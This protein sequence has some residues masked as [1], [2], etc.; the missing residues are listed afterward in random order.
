MKNLVCKCGHSKSEHEHRGHYSSS[1]SLQDICHE[2]LTLKYETE[3][4]FI[5]EYHTFKPDNLLYLEQILKG[6]K[7]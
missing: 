2:C 3:N 5:K 4:K 6:M 7:K 1:S